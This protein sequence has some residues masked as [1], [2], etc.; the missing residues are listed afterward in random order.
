MTSRWLSLPG[1][2]VPEILATVGERTVE[3]VGETRGSAAR[4]YSNSAIMAVTYLAGRGIGYAYIILMVKRL[5]VKTI[6]AY[7][8]L[9]SAS[10]LLELVSN[11]GLDKILTREIASTGVG[12]GQGYFQ[13]ALQ[14][15]I[16]VA[17]VSA[18]AAWALLMVFFKDLTA[19]PFSVALYLSSIFFIVAAR[20]CEAFL[21]AHERLFPVA[22]SQLVERVVIFGAVAAL[23]FGNVSFN[24]LLRIAPL[25]SLA[26][27][28]VVARSTFR[29]W[30]PKVIS[31]RPQR[32]K[33]LGQALELFSV[34]ILS[35]V[36]GRSDMFLVAK[37][38][39][40]GAAGVYQICYKV[41][42]LCVSLFS[43]FLQA[44][45]PRMVRDRSR[46]SLSRVLGGGTALVAIPA[47]III[48]ARHQLLGALKPEYLSGSNAL[49]WL[50]L[51]IPLMYI[52]STTANVAI[53][54][55]RTRLLIGAAALLMGTNVALNLAL[56][57]RYAINGA[58][59][60]TFACEL[61]ST[62][63]LVPIVLRVTA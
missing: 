33:L 40:L 2:S 50:M 58:A 25:A 6:G 30:A 53:V 19:S 63:V 8:I 18:T 22:A 28:L 10:M 51:T 12:A 39:G 31:A 35:L 38:N 59:F 43:G 14:I 57:P 54:A 55:G 49:I 20:N 16:V 45:F 1:Q 5:S 3:P 61:M 46:K 52:T 24:E 32:K 11:L 41:F 60:S 13:A 23:A 44:V 26:R 36:Y 4:L 17:A 56:I 62:V 15:R 29:L 34:E 37:M 47:G 42:D 9:V 48:L 27:L 7:A 21:T